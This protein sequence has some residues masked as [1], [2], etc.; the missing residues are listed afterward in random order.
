MSSI[1]KTL[2]FT[3]AAALLW[4]SVPAHAGTKDAWITTK[5]KIAILT[6][7]GLSVKDANVDTVDGNVTIHGTVGTEADKAKA[8]ATAKTIGG[9][10]TVKNLL[11]VMDKVEKAAVKTSDEQIELRAKAELK[12]DPDFKDIKIASVNKGVVLLSGQV[13]SLETKLH[14]VEAVYKVEGVDRVATEIKTVEAE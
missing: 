7:D 3:L 9:V 1:L 2:G 11:V 6:S 5:V 14:A 13:K 4:T 8:E 10:K 12:G